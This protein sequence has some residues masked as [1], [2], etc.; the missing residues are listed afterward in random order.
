MM[1]APSVT[2]SQLDRSLFPSRA[3]RPSSPV[4]AW[5]SASLTPLP[6]PLPP[7]SPTIQDLARYSRERAMGRR[8]NLFP[9]LGIPCSRLG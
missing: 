7:H 6:T 9:S 5:V 3:R 2:G 4:P 1:L 8:R